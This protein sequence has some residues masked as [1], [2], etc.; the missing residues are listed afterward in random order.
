MSHKLEDS[1][2]HNARIAAVSCRLNRVYGRKQ[3]PIAVSV[4]VAAHLTGL[5]R[6]TIYA[7]MAAGRLPW[8]KVGKRRLIPMRCL[9]D[10]LDAATKEAA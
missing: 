8:A 6:S 9:H 2:P 5:S 3:H 4:S 10:W 1:I 7:E